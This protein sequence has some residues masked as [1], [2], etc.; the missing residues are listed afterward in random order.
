MIKLLVQSTVE[1]WWIHFRVTFNFNGMLIKSLSFCKQLVTYI[2]LLCLSSFLT[3]QTRLV[4]HE[5]CAREVFAIYP[6]P[7][8]ILQWTIPSIAHRLVRFTEECFVK[9]CTLLSFV[10]SGSPGG[11]IS[12]SREPLP[13]ISKWSP[14]EHIRLLGLTILR[15]DPFW[16]Q[17]SEFYL[18]AKCFNSSTD[19]P[20][21][22]IWLK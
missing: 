13:L 10:S 1:F 18:E 12:Y 6:S 8:E 20:H 16:L 15:S 11:W 9:L 17:F 22:A 7:T 2:V 19:W 4:S 5:Q 3:K 21:F 14:W